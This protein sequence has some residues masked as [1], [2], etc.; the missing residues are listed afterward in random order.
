[1]IITIASP[2][3]GVGKTA[4]AINIVVELWIRGMRPRFIDGE[5]HGPNAKVVSDFEPLIPTYRATTYDELELAI[6]DNREQSDYVVIDLP[7]IKP[8]PLFTLCTPADLLIIPM[9]TSER[10]LRQ[11][12]P[13]LKLIK[14]QQLRTGGLPEASLIFTFTRQRDLSAR[15]YRQALQPLG[16]PIAETEIRRLDDYRDNAC[17]MRDPLLNARGAATDIRS[18]IDELISPRISRN[19]EAMHG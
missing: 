18:L 6:E 16:I 5:P 1:M 19:K 10:D 8:D 15:S 4:T 12:K 7:G 14:A 2:K 13:F 3:G 11:I 9:Q 17:V